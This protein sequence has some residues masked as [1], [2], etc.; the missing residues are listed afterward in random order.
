MIDGRPS[1]RDKKVRNVHFPTAPRVSQTKPVT[2]LEEESRIGKGGSMAA[3]LS[4]LD[5]SVPDEPRYLPFG[6]SPPHAA[7]GSALQR[8]PPRQGSD[9]MVPGLRVRRPL[10]TRCLPWQPQSVPPCAHASER[11][12]AGVK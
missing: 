3:L 9:P 12:R 2:H 11:N 6:C 4:R 5:L 10:P 7:Q 8:R 1:I